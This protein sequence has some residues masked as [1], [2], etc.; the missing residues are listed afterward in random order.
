MLIDKGVINLE[1]RVGYQVCPSNLLR[2][3]MYQ[4]ARWST[5]RRCGLRKYRN[6]GDVDWEEW[7]EAKGRDVLGGSR[8]PR[9]R[10]DA[11]RAVGW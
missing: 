6:D 4:V 9:Q 11:I 7:K 8:V 3:Y 10:C 1:W 2:F 5:S